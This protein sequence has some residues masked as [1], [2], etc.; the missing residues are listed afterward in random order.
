MANREDDKAAL[1]HLGEWLIAHRLPIAIVTL[2]LTAVMAYFAF[3]NQ[4]S[5]S[6]GDLLPYRH[7]FIHVHQK[8]AE[9]FGGANNVTIMVEAR[10]GTVFTKEIL[11]KVFDITQVVDRLRGVNHDQIDSIAFRTCRYLKMSGGVMTMPPVMRGIPATD[12]HVEEIR[13]IVHTAENIHGILVS[14][15]DK[16][17]LV[18]ANFHEGKVDYRALFGE[19]DER[20]VRPFEDASAAIWVAGEPRLYGWIYRYTNEIYAIF[21]ACVVVMWIL[22]Y[23]Y[24]RDWRGALRPTLT[25][26]ISAIWGLGLVR[27][28]GFPID[29]LALVI[30]FFATARALSHSVQMHDRYYEEYRRSGWNKRRAIV[31]SF[32]ELFV[33]SLSG[34]VTDA[35]GLLVIIL[36]P[37]VILQR[38]AIWSSI[39]VLSVAISEL[40][41]NPIVYDYLKPPEPSRVTQREHGLFQRFVN[42]ATAT[43]LAPGARWLWI[44]GWG[45]VLI[46][47]ATQWRHITVGDPTA[48]SPLLWLDS[49]YNTAHRRIQETFG[50]VEPLI[51]VVE[52]KEKEVLNEP[53][54]VELMEAFQQEMQ[55]DPDIGYS[56][57]LA[58]VVKSVHMIYFDM[59]PRWGVIPIARGEAASLFFF[60]FAGTSTAEIQRFLDL[61]YTNSHVTFFCRNHQGDSVAR[62]VGRARAF[63]A[64]HPSDKVSLRLATGLVGVTA[65]ANEAVVTNDVLMNVLGYGT[66]FLI[67]LF[68]YR[69]F[70]AAS[71]M[72]VPLLLANA[73]A[74]AWMGW[75]NIGINLQTLPVI[76]IGIGFGIDYALYIVSRALEELE[77]TETSAD[78][79]AVAGAVERALQT[80]GKAVTFTVVSFGLA[81]L[82][83]SASS[84]RFNAEMGLLLFLWMVVS[85]LAAVTLLPVLLVWLKPRFL[86]PRKAVD[87]AAADQSFRVPASRAR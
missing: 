75:R 83:W 68:T 15:D 4:L 13:R 12:W 1:Y 80:S 28:M 23:L 79:D 74:N 71:L 31:A 53:E 56:F 41:L 2:V 11:A 19:I 78:G 61:S 24:F 10:E 3:A 40:I 66:I 49:P 45:L 14:L 20:I 7:P 29:P 27:M 30:P 21:A 67:V 64:A 54:V 26:V 16:A 37:I 82:A 39:W 25:G 58:D 59:S 43:I 55:Q 32:A 86:T 84:I 35:L 81:T 18:R 42:G 34:I 44:G 46:V 33:P 62:I 77:T 65:A 36:V 50:G 63:V 51:V 57:S 6:F 87:G 70:V 52:G 17:A 22:L 48:A 60:F 5:T 73:V 69:S 9:Q 47:A 72:M 38:I 8:Y 85:F 76:T